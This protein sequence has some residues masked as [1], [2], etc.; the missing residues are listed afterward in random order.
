MRG[1]KAGKLG[2]GSVE[3]DPRKRAKELFSEG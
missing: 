1:Q 3:G 2:G